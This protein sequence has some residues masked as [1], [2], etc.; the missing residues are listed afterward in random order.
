MSLTN[1]PTL[2]TDRLILR[3]P[4]P[5][6]FEPIAAFLADPERP[7]GFGGTKNRTEAWRWWASS[8]GHWHLRG[9]GYWT[10]CDPGGAVLGIVGLWE[11][12]GW[13]EV[14]MGWVALADAEGKGIMAEAATRARAFA[15]DT[16]GLPALSSNIKP[17]NTR[18]IR[19]AERL[20]C[21]VERRYV[22]V[23]HGD[24][25]LYRHPGPEELAA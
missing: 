3:G 4:E 17:D 22:N 19:L 20:G 12:D 24:M 21:T 9:Y 8:I 18:S 10:I 23:S 13:P 25:L 16:L 11:P 7:R 14:E 2:T 5:G 15:Y 6:D 1:A